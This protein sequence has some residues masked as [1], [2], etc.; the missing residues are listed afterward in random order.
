MSSRG[1]SRSDP[2]GPKLRWWLGPAVVYL[3]MFATMLLVGLVPIF[4]T[5]DRSLLD[6]ISHLSTYSVALA[7]T[8]L[9]V[10]RYERKKNFWRSVGMKRENL[11]QSFIWIFALYVILVAA[12]SLYWE[13]VKWGM[14]SDP[15]EAMG[16]FFGARPDW[17]FAYLAFAFFI[18]VAF[19]E[20]LVFRGFMLDR[21]LVKGAAFAILS[22]SLLFTVLHVWYVTFGISA[23]PLY[24]ALFILTV[25]W[26]FVYYKT[27]NIVGLIVFHG[28][29]NVTLSV[30]HFFGAQAKAAMNSMIFIFS[31]VCL[32]YLLIIYL[33][34]LFAEIELLVKGRGKSNP[35]HF[36]GSFAP[37]ERYRQITAMRTITKM[38]AAMSTTK[39]GGASATGR[40]GSVGILSAVT[41]KRENP[42]VSAVKYM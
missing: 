9:H 2:R 34:G 29:Y 5:A 7:L 25:Y 1:T 42:G 15:Q 37:R 40:V 6:V 23:L 30:E 16:E 26:G 32:G 14:G 36:S 22:S 8:Y 35:H 27:R 12:L 28:L 11:A 33:R 17:Y 24:G 41:A 39:T 31:V 38:T 3:C 21:F 19:T 20:E 18:P 10:R 13:A 4:I